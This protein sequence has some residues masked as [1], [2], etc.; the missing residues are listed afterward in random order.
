MHG[1]QVL[2]PQR[3]LLQILCKPPDIADALCMRFAAVRVADAPS[4]IHKSS[5]RGL[6]QLE[7]E[8]RACDFDL[9]ANLDHGVSADECDMSV[10]AD[11][12]QLLCAAHASH[13]T[14]KHHQFLACH[15]DIRSSSL[16]WCCRK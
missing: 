9:Q 1:V 11:A 3:H 8:L 15:C 7:Q 4:C 16:F 5:S 14:P 6:S 10:W 2:Q 13:S 12:A